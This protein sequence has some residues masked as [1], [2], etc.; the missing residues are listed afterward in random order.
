MAKNPENR[1][2]NANVKKSNESFTTAMQLF[3]AGCVAEAYLLLVRRFF[4]NG[5]VEQVLKLEPVLRYQSYIGL[6]ILALGLVV[7]AALRKD[8]GKRAMGLWISGLGLFLGV[9]GWMCGRFLPG[10]TNL[11][12]M[13]VPVLMLAVLIFFL[14]QREFFYS[15]AILGLGIADVW[16][17]R[18]GVGNTNWNALVLVGTAVLVLLLLAVALGCHKLEQNKGKWKERQLLPAKADYF[19]ITLS[20]G[21]SVIAMAIS[22]LSAAVA[23]YAMW[24]LAVCLFA[25]AVYYT[26]KQL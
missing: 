2:Q 22:V 6:A 3:L 4:V 5:Q 9:S 24:A 15:F 16:A 14:Y 11:L 10:G 18:R 8:K 17:L 25:L 20:C 23:Y 13:A 1:K 26:V 19:A 7:T 12:L 21:L